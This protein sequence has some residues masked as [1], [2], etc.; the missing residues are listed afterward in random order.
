[1][2]IEACIPTIPCPEVQAKTKKILKLPKNKTW[3]GKKLFRLLLTYNWST[4]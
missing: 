3:F 4:S 2:L 1:M